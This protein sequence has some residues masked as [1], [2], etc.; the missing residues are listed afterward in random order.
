MQKLKDAL[1]PT[2]QACDLSWD[3]VEDSGMLEVSLTALQE[4]LTDPSMLLSL[5]PKP[6]SI[7]LNP[8]P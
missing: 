1:E 2:L 7:N 3:D 5:R 8:E 6:L 4:A